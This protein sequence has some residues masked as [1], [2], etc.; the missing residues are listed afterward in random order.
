MAKKRRPIDQGQTLPE[1]SQVSE[2]APVDGRD[3]L[4]RVAFLPISTWAYKDEPSVR[5]MGP[6]AQDFRAAFGLGEDDVTIDLR[7]EVNVTLAAIK[8]LYR[9]VQEQKAEIDRLTEKIAELERLHTAA[10]RA[11]PRKRIGGKEV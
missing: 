9:M 7:D 1:A 8:A 4:A 10:P 11:A 6:M 3:I 2:S 5:H